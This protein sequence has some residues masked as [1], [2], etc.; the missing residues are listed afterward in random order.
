LR[1]LEDRTVSRLGENLWREV[2]FRIIAA[3]NRDLEPS[4]AAGAFGADLREQLAIVLIHL[5]PLRERLEERSGAG[6]RCV[7]HPDQDPGRTDES[8]RGNRRA[9]A[10]RAGGGARRIRWDATKAAKLLG[11]V[12]RGAARD[13]GGTVRAMKRRLRYR[14]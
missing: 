7:A 12:G 10:D 5:P 3:T 4:V 9:A 13:P 14:G 8:S 6:R 2:D 1:V 11:T